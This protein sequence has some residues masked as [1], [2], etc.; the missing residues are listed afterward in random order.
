MLPSMI[1]LN[2][3]NSLIKNPLSH[4]LKFL[5]NLLNDVEINNPIYNFTLA[6]LILGTTGLSMTL[7]S[8]KN[9]YSVGSFN[10]E[11][12]ILMTLLTLI[13]II[14]AYIGVL[15]HLIAGLVRYKVN[16]FK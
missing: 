7:N 16:S 15:L 8:V 9:I 12:T 1:Q 3:K 14:V 4:H 2:N 5:L 6:G 10:L 13:G 11:N